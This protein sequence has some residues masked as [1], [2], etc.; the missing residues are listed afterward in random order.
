MQME[1][2]RYFQW[3]AGEK[4]G[5]VMIFDKYFTDGDGTLYIIFKDGSRIN[6]AYVASLNQRDLTG[7]LMAEVDSPDNVWT[8][9]EEWIG[10]KEEVWVEQDETNPGHKVCVQPFIPGRKV[11][12]LIPPNPT[13]IKT[14]DKEN[15][16]NINNEIEKKEIEIIKQETNNIDKNDPIYILMT[17]SKKEDAEVSMNIQISLPPKELYNIIKKSFDG[18][19]EKFIEYII[20]DIKVDKIKESL[21]TAI[22]DMYENNNEKITTL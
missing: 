16:N 9:K 12:K 4:R 20:Q 6:S 7:M 17:K 8:F 22:Y 3:I 21:K 15:I 19:I 11:I 18:G 10:R 14:H 5:Q 2:N 13:I 1:N